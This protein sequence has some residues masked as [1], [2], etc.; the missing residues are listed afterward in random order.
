MAMVYG[1]TAAIRNP[2]F[3]PQPAV[4]FSSSWPRTESLTVAFMSS[5][6]IRRSRRHFNKVQMPFSPARGSNTLRLARSN[7]L[8]SG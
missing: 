1:D 6:R 5:H 2:L 3:P 7:P 4:P 8:A